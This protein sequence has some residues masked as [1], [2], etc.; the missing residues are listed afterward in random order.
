MKNNHLIKKNNDQI[1]KEKFDSPPM[2]YCPEKKEMVSNR[3]LGCIFY[4][5]ERTK[6]CDYNNFYPS[7]KKGREWK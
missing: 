3:C 6:W 2:V 1:N 7:L 4:N 5:P